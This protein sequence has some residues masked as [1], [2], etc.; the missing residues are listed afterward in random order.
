MHPDPKYLNTQLGTYDKSGFFAKLPIGTSRQPLK[1]M[2]VGRH[3][4]IE[5]SGL[6]EKVCR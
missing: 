6:R 2:Q 1:H 4:F 3:F 5:M